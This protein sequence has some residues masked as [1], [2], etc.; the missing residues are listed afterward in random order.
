VS[1]RTVSETTALDWRVRR[2][3]GIRLAA[4]SNRGPGCVVCKTLRPSPVHP[5]YH[6]F[7]RR[8]PKLASAFI[9]DHFCSVKT[10]THL[11]PNS[12]CRQCVASS[13]GSAL[14]RDQPSASLRSSNLRVDFGKAKQVNLEI[15]SL[16]ANEAKT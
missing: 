4:G 2:S 9:V 5:T 15:L 11:A 8:T 14:V 12:N 16:A 3:T 7:G 1:A 13:S 6:G 10:Q